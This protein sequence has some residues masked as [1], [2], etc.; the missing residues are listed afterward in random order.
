[1]PVFKTAILCAL[2]LASGT[3]VA[4]EDI[5]FGTIAYG[6]EVKLDG[7][8]FTMQYCINESKTK[9]KYKLSLKTTADRWF[10]VGWS[11]DGIMEGTDSV[12]AIPGSGIEK[13]HL[14]GYAANKLSEDRQDL[15]DVSITDQRIESGK[16]C[17]YFTRLLTPRVIEDNVEVEI[18]EGEEIYFLWAY[19]NGQSLR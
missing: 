3:V 4:N 17:A 7:S 13:Y 6:P 9:I 12:I 15:E 18:P 11:H 10:G 1:M 2:F 14:A 8:D 19:G 5:C 16:L